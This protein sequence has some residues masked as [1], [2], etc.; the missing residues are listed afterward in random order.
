MSKCPTCGVNKAATIKSASRLIAE[1]E[2][3]SRLLET[4]NAYGAGENAA[5][6]KAEAEVERLRAGG[7]AR[8]QRTTQWCAEAEA[9]RA[10]RDA[11]QAFAKWI[12]DSYHSDYWPEAKE[13]VG[14]A[15]AA[16]DAARKP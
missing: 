9:L 11:L 1:N 8:D 5:R 13:I 15:R 10:E 2:R 14:E 12:I 4:A 16:I 7:C 6:L 3:L